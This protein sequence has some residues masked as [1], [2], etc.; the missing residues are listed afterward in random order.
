MTVN[1]ILRGGLIAPMDYSFLVAL[2]TRTGLITYDMQEDLCQV[3]IFDDGTPF[4]FAEGYDYGCII[5][6]DYWELSN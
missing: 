2:N 6:K 1:F 3:K 4:A 5:I